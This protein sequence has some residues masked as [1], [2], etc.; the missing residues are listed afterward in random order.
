MLVRFLRQ[1]VRNSRTSEGEKISRWISEVREL[2][3]PRDGDSLRIGDNLFTVCPWPTRRSDIVANH[4]AENEQLVFTCARHTRESEGTSPGGMACR[5]PK[6]RSRLWKAASASARSLAPN[7]GH[8][9]SV[10]CS[11]A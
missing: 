5:P 11:S 9:R 4:A 3:I 6:R 2:G 10:K 1:D 7:S 8:I